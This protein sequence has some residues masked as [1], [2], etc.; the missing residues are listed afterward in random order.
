[1]FDTY[2]QLREQPF[3]VNPDPRFL[4]L[5]KTH[6]EAFSSLL[7]RIQI[8][9]GF[10]AMIAQ[11][12]M[13]KTTLLYHLLHQLQPVAR[14]AF[15]FQTQCTSH[16]LLRHLLSEFEC[17]T[18]ITDA[19][20]MSR[21]L[22]SLLLT[23]AKAGRRCVVVID[24]AQNLEPEVLETVRLLSDFETPR[25]KLLQI[26]LSGQSELGEKLAYPRLL[27]LRQRL[28]SI[29]HIQTFTPEETVLYIAH[30]LK[31]AGYGGKVSQLFDLRAL[32][33]IAQLSEGIPRIIN[34]LCCSALSL[35]FALDKRRIE[36]PI[37][38]E[39]ACDLGLSRTVLPA[40]AKWMGS[41]A[42]SFHN[43][44]SEFAVDS[45][46]E[47]IETSV[48]IAAARNEE[49]HSQSQAMETI[50]TDA[51]IKS[52]GSQVEAQPP[53]AV[54]ALASPETNRK[55][56]SASESK[57]EAESESSPGL[58]PVGVG[59]TKVKPPVGAP[60]A[61]IHAVHRN[62]NPS[63]LGRWFGC[64]LVFWMAPAT[65]VRTHGDIAAQKAV[66][67]AEEIL[68]PSGS[69]HT[70]AANDISD[71][72]G[73]RAH[74]RGT[75]AASTSGAEQHYAAFPTKKT[76]LHGTPASEQMPWRVRET[77]GA[78]DLA[79]DSSESDQLLAPLP[80]ISIPVT[81]PSIPALEPSSTSAKSDVPASPFGLMAGL[82][83]ASYLPQKEALLHP[84][85]DYPE[86]QIK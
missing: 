31:I 84:A 25:R 13:G 44:P 55:R 57:S 85:P 39:V 7:Y 86:A 16:E 65:H 72:A 29:I 17:D 79:L 3:G 63:F 23:E 51:G 26:I 58:M 47:S 9:S 75:G 64:A 15:L 36:L 22:K 14:T 6:R 4:Y 11:P 41:S 68:L 70:L 37:I 62:F 48:A 76:G 5:S 59:T 30:R 8:D 74:P 83:D 38:E 61:R 54:A 52:L 27:Q 50:E 69:P 21:E 42:A 45:C 77:F 43:S 24:E 12:G 19:V 10:L 40:H 71:A 80:L 2:Y 33:R 46:D 20:R 28:S 60:P 81:A 66:S 53:A 73:N 56:V 67:S 82:P 49:E 35:G 78:L 34:N 32:T 18:T 1:M